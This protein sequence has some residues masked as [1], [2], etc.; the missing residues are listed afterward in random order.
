MKLIIIILLLYVNLFLSAYDNNNNKVLYV[1]TKM[2]LDLIE[3]IGDIN[4]ILALNDFYEDIKDIKYDIKYPPSKKI[5]E[6]YH[7]IDEN[8]DV[9]SAIRDIFNNNNNNNDDDL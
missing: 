2:N 7:L 4:H 5:L 1:T 9:H 6:Q 3:S 8:G